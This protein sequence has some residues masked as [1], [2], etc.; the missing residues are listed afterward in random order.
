[1]SKTYDLILFGASGFTGSLVAEYLFKQYGLGQSLRWA[2]AGRNREKLEAIRKD[3]GAEDLAIEIA[4]SLDPVALNELVQKTKVICTTVGP[5]ALYGNELLQA[6]VEN[7]VH[8]CDLTGEVQWIRR[9]IDLHHEQ[10]QAHQ[11]KIVHC[12]GFDSIPSDMGV[13]YLQK[14][15]Q[16]AWGS[17]AQSVKFRLRG[18]KGGFSGG[19]VA[20]LE[21]VLKE[22]TEESK[23]MEEVI[24]HPY[25]L[26]PEGQKEGPDGADLK[27]VVYDKDF[28]AWVA[29]FIM[30]PIN[31]KIVRRS[32][33]LRGF[34]YG[35]DFQYE[36]AMYSGKGTLSWLKAKGMAT[37]SNALYSPN[38]ILKKVMQPF[39]PKTGDGP[40][41][42]QREEGFFKVILLGKSA[43]GK[44]LKVNV[45]GDRDPGYGST[46]KM[47]GEAAVALALDDLNDTYGVITPSTAMGDA[48]LKRLEEHAGLSFEVA[49][50]A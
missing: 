21:N 6:C 27:N 16:K 7:K 5:Y 44:S 11:T 48:L 18:A 19:T 29:P 43:E 40:S 25:G 10:A 39:L 23:L 17:Y 9:S 50:G 14:E 47:L 1:M 13:Y 28:G 49:G 24:M 42:K 38:S 32:H 35:R 20:S 22:A 3:L 33:A 4:D 2:I 12:C 37:F 8:Y 26:N 46:S 15:A 31:T 34:P 41:E 30:A 45:K 36:E